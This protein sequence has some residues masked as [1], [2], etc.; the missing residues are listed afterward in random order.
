ML[1]VLTDGLTEVFDRKG[2]E[3]G[4]SAI[5]ERCVG[6]SDSSLRTCFVSGDPQP[7]SS[8]LRWMIRLRCLRDIE[9]GD[10]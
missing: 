7:R 3:I 1:L 6:H 10:S 5:K 8:A 2:N 4:V 9:D